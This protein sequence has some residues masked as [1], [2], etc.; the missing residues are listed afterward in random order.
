MTA[1]VAERGLKPTQIARCESVRYLRTIIIIFTHLC[2]SY[3]SRNCNIGGEGQEDLAVSYD[4][5]FRG[6]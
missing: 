5:N 6:C 4:M 3:L 1:A 2:I